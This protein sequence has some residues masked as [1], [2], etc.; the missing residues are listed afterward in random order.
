MNKRL[1]SPARRGRRRVKGSNTRRRDGPDA[2]TLTQAQAEKQP[3]AV[4]SNSKA[5]LVSFT[6]YRRKHTCYMSDVPAPLAPPP[7]SCTS[8]PPKPKPSQTKESGPPNPDKYVAVSATSAG[9]REPYSED[10][11]ATAE[12]AAFGGCDITVNVRVNGAPR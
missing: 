9:A 6:V 4:H 11:P 10:S 5:Q 12:N 7:T 8:H 3:W 1:L 2:L